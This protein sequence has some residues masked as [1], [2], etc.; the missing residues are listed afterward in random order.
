MTSVVVVGSVNLDAITVCER[1]PQPGETVTGVSVAFGQGGKGANQARSAARSGA[2]TVFIGAVG[3]DDAAATVLDSLESAGVDV[4]RVRRTS[5]ST[6]F[7]N[8]TV[9][10]SGENHI[11]VVPGANESVT[12]DDAARAAIGAAD[13]VLL[14]LEIPMAVVVEAARAARTAGTVVLLNPSPVQPLPEELVDLLDGVIVNRDEAAA[15]AD[16]VRRVPNVI[17]TL[18]GGGARAT[19]PGGTVESPGLSVR[20]VDTTGAGD[21]FAGALA[22]AWDRPPAERLLRANAA[23]ALTATAAG[24]AAAPSRDEVDAFLY[25]RGAR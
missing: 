12:L 18:G 8:V 3:D 22:A 5:G 2:S 17:T 4:T 13:V 6:G 15:L 24:A 7:A 25:E 14:Q 10:S 19:G 16:A 1:F 11:V 20:V 9:D 21:A 23:G